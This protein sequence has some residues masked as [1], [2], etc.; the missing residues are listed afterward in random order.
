M[1]SNSI[2]NKKFHATNKKAHHALMRG[3]VFF[4]FGKGERVEGFFLGKRMMGSGSG[5]VPAEIAKKFFVIVR[6]SA[7]MAV[8][9][10]VGGAWQLASAY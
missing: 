6:F 8:M 9:L 1:A 7:A 4:S 10:L 3:P 2:G 5:I